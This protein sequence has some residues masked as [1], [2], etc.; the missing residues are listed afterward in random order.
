M[1]PNRRRLVL[2]TLWVE[3]IRTAGP[4]LDEQVPRQLVSPEP[5]PSD[6]TRTLHVRERKF[7][8]EVHIQ[9]KVLD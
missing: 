2:L 5:V 4:A 8:M 6:A 1:A 9:K 7:F 3:T